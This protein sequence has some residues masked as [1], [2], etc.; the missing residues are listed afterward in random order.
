[1]ACFVFQIFFFFTTNRFF[2][3]HNHSQMLLPDVRFLGKKKKIK[4]MTYFVSKCF[5]FEQFPLALVSSCKTQPPIAV[6][7]SIYAH[8]SKIRHLP[9]HCNQILKSHAW[10]SGKCR[11]VIICLY[12]CVCVCKH[13]ICLQINCISDRNELCN[14]MKLTYNAYEYLYRYIVTSNFTIETSN[15]THERQHSKK[16]AYCIECFLERSALMH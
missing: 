3:F 16:I 9:R 2:F 7:F 8:K 4:L 5:E 6:C 11:E 15:F 1:M 13:Y 12:S 14:S 10:V